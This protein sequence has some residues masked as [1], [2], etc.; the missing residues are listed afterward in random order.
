MLAEHGWVAPDAVPH[1]R[2]SHAPLRS[3]RA[4]RNTSPCTT[5]CR[6]SRSSTRSPTTTRSSAIMRQVLGET[7]F[8]HPLKIARLGVPGAL[9][10]VDASA[11][12]LPEQPGNA[13]PH[14]GVGPGG[15]LPEGAGRARDLR[16]SHRYGVLP[17]D[18]RPRRR[19]TAR[20]C[21]PHEMLEELRWVTTEYSTGDVVLFTS[22]TVHAS[23]HNASEFFMRISVD[24]RYQLEG[25]ELTESCLEPHFQRLAGKTCTR[26]GSRTATS[27]T[28]RTSTTRSC[29]SRT[30]ILARSDTDDRDDVEAFLAYERRR[31]ARFQRRTERLAAMLDGG[32]DPPA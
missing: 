23:M 29:R 32:A 22:L 30:S 12:G 18:T 11:P 28:G 15:R 17:L 9:R 7:A 16:G 8:P 13:E 1:A 2:A 10:G 19:A 24:F 6:S 20:R 26:A 4:T 31:D 14:R 5:R 25:E 3:A 21:C 27:T